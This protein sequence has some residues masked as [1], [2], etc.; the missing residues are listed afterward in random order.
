MSRCSNLLF[1]CCHYRSFVLLLLSQGTQSRFSDSYVS[2]EFLRLFVFVS[3]GLSCPLVSISV[4]FLDS[5]SDNAVVE[6]DG[7]VGTRDIVTCITMS[8]IFISI[9][10]LV[11]VQQEAND[12]LRPCS[13][14]SWRTAWSL[15]HLKSKRTMSAVHFNSTD[16]G[17]C[18]RGSFESRATGNCVGSNSAPAGLTEAKWRESLL[19]KPR[20]QYIAEPVELYW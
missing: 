15:R 14:H 18:N 9:E 8:K 16:G 4:P 10:R 17:A 1:H 11:V 13:C 12:L 20:K 2:D 3:P 5:Y 6:D 19:H 7:M